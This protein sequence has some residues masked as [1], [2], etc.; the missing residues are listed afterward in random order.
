VTALDDILGDLAHG[1]G[2]L[3]KRAT[4]ALFAA[5]ASGLEP[6]FRRWAAVHGHQSGS[7]LDRALSA[8]FE[9]AC[10]GRTAVDVAGILA[11]LE[12]GTPARESRKSVASA[13]AQDCWV[14]ADVAIR[15][16]V[17][18]AFVPGPVVEYALEPIL[19]AAT[20]RLM[21][22]AP[23]AGADETDPADKLLEDA[24]VRAAVE[25]MWFAIMRLRGRP[26]PD[27]RT[28]EELRL[29]AVALLPAA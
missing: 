7:L 2:A 9:L 26:E 17:E 16:H 15:V 22:N 29:R 13:T 25:F 10:T 27:E 24:A 4:S 5:S 12:S 19:Q 3:S 6:G 8:G 11:E 21:A 23:R 20:E 28:V 1:V 18:P 14:C